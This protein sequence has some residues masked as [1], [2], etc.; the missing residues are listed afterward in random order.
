MKLDSAALMQ[1]S[2]CYE[3]N[4]TWTVSVSWG[5]AVQI[6]R[7]IFSPREM[8]MPTRTFLNW[9]KRGDYTAYAFNTR[10]LARHPCQKPFVYYFS[11]ARWDDEANLT[12]SEYL[13]HNESHP[14]CR[15]KMDEPSEIER[16]VVYKKSDPQLWARVSPLL[17][18]ITYQMIEHF[19]AL[20]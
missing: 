17:I 5:F 15:W 1:Q 20:V 6:V 7:G 19:D 10:P 12:V 11:E 2:I 8:E 14:P 18:L 13:W 9:Y 3:K 16:V 4:K